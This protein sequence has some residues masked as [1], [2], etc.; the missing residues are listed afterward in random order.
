M[1]QPSLTEGQ[2]ADRQ[3]SL[4][5]G[6]TERQGYGDKGWTGRGKRTGFKRLA[7]LLILL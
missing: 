7:R 4:L 3:S 6:Q 1:E 5:I 2:E